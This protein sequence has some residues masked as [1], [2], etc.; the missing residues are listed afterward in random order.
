[1]PREVRVT[2][3]NYGSKWHTEDWAKLPTFSTFSNGACLF[4]FFF[5]FYLRGIRKRSGKKHSR[6]KARSLD[7]RHDFVSGYETERNKSWRFALTLRDYSYALRSC[8]SGV[9]LLFSQFG[10]SHLVSF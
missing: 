1:M 8:R 5:F 9:F 6:G 4:F 10:F 2:G 7:G 3:I